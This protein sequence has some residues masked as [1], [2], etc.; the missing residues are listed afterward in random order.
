MS[1]DGTTV[2]L[3][4]DALDIDL[5][6]EFG[7]WESFGDHISRIDSIDNPSVGKPHTHELWP[8]LITG[9][10]PTEHGIRSHNPNGGAADWAHPGLRGIARLAS[11]VLPESV[12]AWVGRRLRS[13]GAE[14]RFRG[15]DYYRERGIATVFDGRTARPLAIPNYRTD[16]DD[17]LGVVVD[18]GADLS[19][20]LDVVQRDGDTH[21]DPT[22]D[23]ARY[24]ER[25]AGAAAQKIGAVRAALDRAYDL[26]WVW[27]GYLDSA[28]HLD[29]ATD[30]ALQRRAYRHAAEWTET[31]R[32]ALAPADRLVCV[33]DH[34]LQDGE[35]THTATIAADDRQH[36]A[37]VDSVLDV[38]PLVDEITPRSSP[39]DQPPLRGVY[40]RRDG[41]SCDAEAVREQLQDLGYL[42]GTA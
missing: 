11:Y 9:R 42:E 14:L 2:V 26:V 22:V 40:D 20:V 41:P 37:Q 33:S 29:P 31:I 27:L 5:C 19:G 36:V 24:E 28:G 38:A 4:W 6:R 10:H 15:P 35:H 8:T 16:A 1:D 7:V 32:D 34:G 12:R 18:R 21:H 3:G 30:V 39:T 25:L 23:M 13:R 17:A